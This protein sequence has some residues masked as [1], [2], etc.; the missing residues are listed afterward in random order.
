MRDRDQREGARRG[1]SFGLLRCGDDVGH[2]RLRFPELRAATIVEKGYFVHEYGCMAALAERADLGDKSLIY[3]YRA[4]G[5]A[6]SI[7]GSD[8][9]EC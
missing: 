4:L 1:V 7:I 6:R 5:F 9:T 2:L 3:R 8:H